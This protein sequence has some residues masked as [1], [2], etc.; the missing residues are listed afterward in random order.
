VI[1]MNLL[2]AAS[3]LQVALRGEMTSYL[4]LRAVSILCGIG[5]VESAL[6]IAEKVREE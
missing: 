3:L 1:L 4:M 5:D 2:G 6:A